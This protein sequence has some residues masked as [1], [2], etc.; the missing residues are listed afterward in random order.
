MKKLVFKTVDS[1]AE[2]QV[3]GLMVHGKRYNNKS[4]QFRENS[5][6]KCNNNTH[7]REKGE[8]RCNNNNSSYNGNC[9]KGPCHYCK[10]P[11]HYAR[12]CQYKKQK[13]NKNSSNKNY[14][15]VS[16]VT[17]N[18]DDK[19]AMFS[20]ETVMVSVETSKPLT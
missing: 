16:E 6:S 10:K 8:S 12:E 18:H 19:V 17:P 13:K 14:S 4:F 15:L 7:L 3:T 1:L 20:I 2:R 5:N 9:K 11:G